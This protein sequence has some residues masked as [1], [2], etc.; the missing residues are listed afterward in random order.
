MTVYQIVGI[1]N[2]GAKY[3]KNRHNVGFLAVNFIANKQNI[4]FKKIDRFFSEIAEFNFNGNKIILQKPHTF[5]NNS[6]I[7]VN[8][9][10]SFYKGCKTIVIHDD[11]DIPFT[12]FK[13]KK[14]GGDAGHNGIKNIIQTVNNCFTKVRIGIS[15]PPNPNFLIM[16]YVL[17]NF[18][19]IDLQLLEND[20]LPNVENA[21]LDIIKNGTEFAMNKYN[22]L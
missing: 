1:G 11:I 2:V 13:I 19:K 16:D 8:A 22:A 18:S 15:R 17:S 6:G 7:A 20:I 4:T 3:A 14:G 12:K 21:V 10:Q 5:I 9:L